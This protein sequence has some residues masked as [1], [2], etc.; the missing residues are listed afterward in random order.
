MNVRNA[1]PQELTEVATALASEGPALTLEDVVQ[2]TV[3]ALRRL[4]LGADRL[5]P[6][7]L[8]RFARRDWLSGRDLR[9]PAAGRAAGLREDGALLVRPAQ[10]DEIPLRSGSVELAAV[11]HTR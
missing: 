3:S 8:T 11:S 5:T 7:E 6:A 10:G 4:D 2:P 9:A 1:V